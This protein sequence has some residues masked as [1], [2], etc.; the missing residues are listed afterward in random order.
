[1]GLENGDPLD[2][3]SYALPHHRAFFGRLRAYVRTADC[4]GE[5]RVTAAVDGLRPGVRTLLAS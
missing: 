2:D 5:I 4:G 3:D 1:M